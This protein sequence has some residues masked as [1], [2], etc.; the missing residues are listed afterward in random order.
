MAV[1]SALYSATDD[2]FA[3]IVCLLVFQLINEFPKK[4]LL[5][6]YDLLVFLHVPQPAPL[7]PLSYSSESIGKISFVLVPSSNTVG[8]LWMLDDVFVLVLT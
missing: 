7:K 6:K 4:I 5:P 2:D 3:T 8:F 1:A